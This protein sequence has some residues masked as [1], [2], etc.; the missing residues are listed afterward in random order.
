MDLGLVG[1]CAIVTGGASGIGL[2]TAGFLRQEGVKLLLADRNPNALAS[3]AAQL[4]ADGGEIETFEVD[5]R[6]AEQC[7]AMVEAA[8]ERFG[9]VDILI[10]SAGIAGDTTLFA[11]TGPEQWKDL[12]DINLGGVLNC[13]HAVTEHMVG[14]RSGKIVSLASEAGRANEK[15]IVVYGATKGGV[16]SFTRGL[17]LEL[18]RYSIN[19]NCVCPGVTHSP[20]TSYLDQSEELEAK[21]ASAYPLG[22]LGVPEDIAPMI[23]FLCSDRSSWITGQAISISGGFGRS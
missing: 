7:R 21:F 19:V 3:A 22:R 5:V 4:S 20:M 17:A 2:C 11:D 18:G 10:N 23:T 1:K 6:D 14:R 9:C 13:C 15:R 8:I 12:I 16:I